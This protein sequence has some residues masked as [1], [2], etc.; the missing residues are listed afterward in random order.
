MSLSYR[1]KSIFLHN[2]DRFIKNLENCKTSP[3]PCSHV[4]SKLNRLISPFQI[5]IFS[6]DSS[7]TMI[8]YIHKIP[9]L[10]QN[11]LS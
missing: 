3:I 4:T 7:L 11:H 5:F 6:N 2:G 10:Y 1:Q 9:N 8:F